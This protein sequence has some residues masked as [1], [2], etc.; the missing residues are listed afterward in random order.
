MT[1][2]L[3]KLAYQ[4][5]QQGKSYFGFTHKTLSARLAKLI[6]PP[7]EVKTQPISPELLQKGQQRLDELLETDWQDAENGVYPA[8]LLFDHPWEDFFRYYPLVWLDLP[9]IWDR[10][11]RKQ[12]QEFSPDIDTEGY[13]SYYVQNFH[14]QTDGYLSDESASLYD[15]QVELLFNGGADPMRRRI[16]APLKRG[17]SDAFADV[18][19]RQI[20]V[21]DVATGTGRTLRQIRG[22]LPKASLYGMDLSPAYLRKANQLLSELPGELPQ[23]CQANA[24]NLPYQDNYFHGVTCVFTFHELPPEVR[25]RVMEECYRV[26]QPGGTFVICDSIQ[27]FDLPEFEPFMENFSAMFHEPYHRHYITDDLVARLENA[28]FAEIA[29]ENHFMSKYWVARKP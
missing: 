29:T 13:P 15:L 24:E 22:A 19:P 18:P 5:F 20:R 1:D 27:V 23:L 25:Q 6:A 26:L 14:H 12:Y 3:T 4:T 2:T 11:S 9:K 28:G 8:S 17:L 21:L 10:V 16:L 7:R